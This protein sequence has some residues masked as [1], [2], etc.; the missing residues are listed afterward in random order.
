MRLSLTAFSPNFTNPKPLDS[1]HRTF[2]PA[3]SS[4]LLPP[5]DTF[6][7]LENPSPNRGAQTC[8]WYWRWGWTQW[9]NQ[10]LWLPGDA[11][12]DATQ[13]RVCAL[14]WLCWL[15]WSCCW[16]A[17]QTPLWFTDI[18]SDLHLCHRSRIQ[19]FH[20]LNFIPLITAQCS[21]LSRFVWKASCSSRESTAPPS[22]CD[23]QMC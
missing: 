4:A 9:E 22:F 23:E 20:L 3:L 19:H 10:L 12:F 14:G 16:A 7:D 11:V 6:K 15:T 18:V 5:S 13:D 8:T 1:P 2:F 17:P 21:N